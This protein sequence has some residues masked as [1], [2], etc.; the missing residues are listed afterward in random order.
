MTRIT[1][2]LIAASVA[3]AA[4]PAAADASMSTAG[5]RQ[6]AERAIAPLRAQSTACFKATFD[7]RTRKVPSQYACVI[8]VASAPGETC[9][10]TVTVAERDRR[11]VSAKVTIPLRCFATPAPL[12]PI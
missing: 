10:V 11:R 4:L 5:A 7:Q 12:G 6:H 1:T 8:T 3:A 9:I 2:C